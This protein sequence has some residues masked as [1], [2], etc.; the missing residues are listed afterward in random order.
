ML[1]AS[2]GLQAAVRE[3][4]TGRKDF[5]ERQRPPLPLSAPAPVIASSA[6]FGP[7]FPTATVGPQLPPQ[8]SAAAPAAAPA[9]PMA[10]A[11]AT[12]AV[13]A[14][15]PQTAA[16]A[17]VAVAAAAAAAGPTPQPAP[18]TATVRAAV[19]DGR[20]YFYVDPA[21]REQGPCPASQLRSWHDQ[22]YFDGSCKVRL[23]TD[24]RQPPEYL[25]LQASGIL[26]PGQPAAAAPAAAAAAATTPAA[27][28]ALPPALPAG[29]T[30]AVD[31]ASGRTY[32]INAATKQTRWV[33]PTEPAAAAPT[34]ALA[35]G[36]AQQ[37]QQQLMMQPQQMYQQQQLMMQQQQQQQQ[38]Q[39]MQ[40]QMQ[41]G[42]GG[43][44][45]S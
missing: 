10:V 19:P 42:Y 13:A 35:A 39:Q 37:Q 30:S 36:G 40:M 43:A 31:P 24:G 33:R 45:R 41:N 25:E 23:A 11:A 8:V 26:R 2:G 7:Q 18:T 38:Q 12:A 21:G 16:A 6:D 9:P 20:L 27:A 1:T 3:L 44:W 29:W 28:A 4:A 14:A 17:T 32:Y 5:K 22:R 15:T 34:S